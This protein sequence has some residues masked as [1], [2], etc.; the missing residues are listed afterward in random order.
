M[1]LLFVPVVVFANEISISCPNSINPGTDILCGVQA[2]F[3]DNVSD[4]VSFMYYNDNV[5]FK[6]FSPAE[7]WTISEGG[8]G[9]AHGVVLSRSNEVSGVVNLGVI[10]YNTSN[11]SNDFSI[12]VYD[13][14]ATNNSAQRI[15]FSNVESISNV[16]IN[17]INNYL[18]S[19]LVNGTDIGFSRNKTEYQYVT[20]DNTVSIVAELDDSL[21]TC[22]DLHRVVNLTAGYNVIDYVVKSESGSLRTYRINI[23]YI[24]PDTSNNNTSNNSNN[25]SNNGT[26]INIDSNINDGSSAV[27]DNNQT[28][29]DSD[30]SFSNNENNKKDEKSKDDVSKVEKNNDV[31]VNN[32]SSEKVKNKMNLLL[33]FVCLI[34][35]VVCAIFI[36]KNWKSL[37]KK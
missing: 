17:H 35:I 14:D 3:S 21:A 7:G 37:Y 23:T 28:N 2:N 15:D 6:S 12:R 16:H 30:K 9:S 1:C 34:L 13:F 18:K 27:D 20:Y 29:I 24:I 33:A 5:I 36:K 22:D 10:S 19:L 8:S 26:N 25:N 11:L 31:T 32:K 4:Q